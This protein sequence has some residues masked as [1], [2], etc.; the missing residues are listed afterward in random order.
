MKD[1]SRPL[2][3]LYIEHSTCTKCEL[4]DR[5]EEGSFPMLFGEGNPRGIMFIGPYPGKDDESSGRPFSDQAGSLLRHVVAKLGLQEVYY[6]T[7]VACRSCKQAYTG[8]GQPIYRTDRSTG[9]QLPLIR[10]EPP[11]P[12]SIAACEQRLHEQIYAVDPILIVAMGSLVTKALAG[13]K[14][15][16]SNA[17]GA[18]HEITIDGVWPVPDLT[19]TKRA[20]I[21]KGKDGLTAPTKTNK[22]RYLMYSTS[23]PREVI[24]NEADK[25]KGNPMQ[26]FIDDM[27]RVAGIYDRYRTE[28][29]NLMPGERSLSI[30]DLQDINT[31]WT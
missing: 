31:Q 23:D 15:T 24:I 21:R 25:R 8:E 27:R 22:V 9:A 28:V 19:A 10:D 6:T 7:I 13:P 18:V 29:F 26:T 12:L 3:D 16:I 30:E 4:A 1:F 17:K 11:S 20:W 14:L 5:R 2:S